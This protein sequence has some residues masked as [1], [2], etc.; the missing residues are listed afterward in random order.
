MLDE[1]EKLIETIDNT[2]KEVNDLWQNSQFYEKIN[3][4][5]LRISHLD[6]KTLIYIYRYRDFINIETKKI[7]CEIQ[8]GEFIRTRVKDLNSIQYKIDSYKKRYE[9]GEVPLN[10]CLND[11]FGIRIVLSE[12]IECEKIKNMIMVKFPQIKFLERNL[13]DKNYHALH[14]YFGKKD[15]YNFQWELQIW[16]VKHKEQN[17]LSHHIYKQE[18][19]KWEQENKGG[20]ENG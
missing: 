7:S 1:L 8:N 20:K 14:L 13:E 19:A 3:L 5:K 15:N 17:Y 12:N 6:E 18:Y 10:K 4:R 16:D 9:N 11:L 2:H